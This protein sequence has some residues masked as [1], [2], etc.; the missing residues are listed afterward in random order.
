[1]QK[2]HLIIRRKAELTAMKSALSL[3]VFEIQE[4]AKGI[5]STQHYVQPTH[6]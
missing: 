1:M 3:I 2:N 5:V 4:L 6:P